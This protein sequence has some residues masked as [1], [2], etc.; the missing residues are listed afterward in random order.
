MASTVREIPEVFGVNAVRGGGRGPLGG[1]RVRGVLVVYP[2]RCVGYPS[3]G[4]AYSAWGSQ[5]TVP[6]LPHGAPRQL[7]PP[8]CATWLHACPHH[9]TEPHQCLARCS[10]AGHPGLGSAPALPLT[11]H[12]Q[13][14]LLSV[15]SPPHPRGTK[16]HAWVGTGGA[17]YPSCILHALLP[18]PGFLNPS[19]QP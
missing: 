12:P 9:S 18:V 17:P 11:A 2:A 5:T 3:W 1:R 16:Q 7:Q 6:L 13:P 14:C 8:G 10:A 4:G 19:T 15:L